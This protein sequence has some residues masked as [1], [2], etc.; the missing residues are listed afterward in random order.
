[1]GKDG[2]VLLKSGKNL[3]LLHGTLLVYAVV[4]V[5][6]KLAGLRMADGRRGATLLFLALEVLTLGAYSILWQQV[7]K[8][9]PLSFAYSNKG[10]CT[11]WTALFGLI[12]FGETLTLGKAVGIL[13][14]LAGVLLVVTDHE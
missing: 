6:A 1:M 14:V 13:V 3:L 4:S 5:F 9:M 12:L 7:L 11:L 2:C 8:R 10:V